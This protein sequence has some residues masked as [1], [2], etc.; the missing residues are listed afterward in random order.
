VATSIDKKKGQV[1]YHDG[2][3]KHIEETLGYFRYIT[4]KH[5]LFHIVFFLVFIAELLGLL[6]F[7]P[8][9]AKSFLLAALVA[10]AV[11]TAFSYFVLRFYFQAKQPEQFLRLRD[12]FIENCQ[13]LFPASADPAESRKGFL[14]AAYNL[15][16][17]LEGQEYQYYQP[18]FQLDTLQPLIQKFSVWCH[19]GHVQ[20]MK[21]LLHTHCLRIQL[22]WV[23]AHPTNLELHTGLA[24]AYALLYKIYQDPAKQGIEAYGFIAKEY[25][26][27]E[28]VQKFQKAAQCALEELKIILHYKPGDAWA[29]SQLGAVYHDL[30]LKDEERKTYELLLQH[31]PHETEIRY[32]LG[33]LYFELGLMAHGLK[34]YEELRKM[35]DPKSDELI[36][37][38]D[39]FHSHL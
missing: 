2:A 31:S 19:W 11:L 7:L 24:S 33:I 21:E 27:P 30:D 37:H 14:Q 34:M 29:L 25:N 28:I 17:R 10:A 32:R 8:F 26:S 22:D 39:F 9:L 38:Y 15:I 6:L 16:H 4:R 5:A 36:G 13:R 35:N 20:L 18:P 12:D 1:F 23:K 3:V